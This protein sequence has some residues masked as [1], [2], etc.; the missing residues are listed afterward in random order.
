[1]AQIWLIGILCCLAVESFFAASGL[2]SPP[3]LV[4]SQVFIVVVLSLIKMFL[5][6]KPE[7]KTDSTVD[8]HFFLNDI[9][10]LNFISWEK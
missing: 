2:Q 1:M 5:V 9:S 8:G 3:A 10:A 4:L 7:E 6:R